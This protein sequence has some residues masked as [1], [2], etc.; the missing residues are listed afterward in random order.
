MQG[1][2]LQGLGLRDQG[3]KAD[4]VHCRQQV[5]LPR[6]PQHQ[7]VRQ[8]VDVLRGAREVR[9]LQNLRGGRCQ[10]SGPLPGL[11]AGAPL[12]AAYHS[13]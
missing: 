2:Q 7:G 10:G 11:R 6:L 5:L 9:E 12:G 1:L 13:V 8:V 4:L 3:L